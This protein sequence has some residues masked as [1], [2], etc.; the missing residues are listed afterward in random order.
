MKAAE[1][2]V[3]DACKG[4]LKLEV[5]WASYA[6]AD[7]MFRVPEAANQL[8]EFAK[9]FCTSPTESKVFAEALKV[10]TIQFDANVPDPIHDRAKKRLIVHA[11]SNSYNIAEHITRSLEATRPRGTMGKAELAQK[12]AFEPKLKAAEKAVAD[13]CK[14]KTAITVDWL[15]YPTANDMFR[16]PEAANAVVTVATAY[17]T[18]PADQKA[19]ADSVKTFNIVFDAD[20]K[21]PTFDQKAKAIELHATSNSYNSEHQLKPIVDTF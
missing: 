4:G 20:M 13:A 21:D 14:A 11:T 8:V 15:S 17:C 12:A 3:N 19:F 9:A 7:D 1:K 16:I 18:T 10:V 2:A 6:K 5:N